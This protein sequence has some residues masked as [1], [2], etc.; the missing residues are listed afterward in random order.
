MKHKI[1][2]DI[3]NLHKSNSMPEIIKDPVIIKKEKE[4]DNR[5]IYNK[6]PEYDALIDKNINKNYLNQNKLLNIQN[7]LLVIYHQKV[8][9]H[10]DIFIKN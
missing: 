2:K 3:K 4:W 9:I 6:I 10:K 1:I 8:V 7:Q 5:F